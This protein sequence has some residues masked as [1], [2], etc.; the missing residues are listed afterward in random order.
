M[1]KLLLLAVLCILL[2]TTIAFA[3]HTRPTGRSHTSHY[4]EC[5]E[6]E[7]DL[8]YD[9]DTGEPLPLCDQLK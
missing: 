3:G 1:R 7:D 5:S 9:D 2:L 8:C 6:S 4:C